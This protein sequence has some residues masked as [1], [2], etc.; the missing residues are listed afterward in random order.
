MT[1]E[2]ENEKVLEEDTPECKL[3]GN[4][5][6]ESLQKAE[7]SLSEYKDKYF[8]SLAE[9]ENLRKR[10][11]HEKQESIA[12]AIE[13]MLSEF[14]LP[15]DSFESALSYTDHLSSELKNWAQGFKMIAAQFKEVLENHGIVKFDSLGNPF[16][17]H[18]H[19]AVEMI[20]TREH[21]DGTVIEEITKG[22]KRGDKV[23]R[24][25]K[26]KVA[27]APL[28]ELKKENTNE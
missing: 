22:Y 23:L 20:L 28:E 1:S 21:K 7:A 24:V 25:A 11:S 26:V 13:K 17:P 27:K 3:G 4:F 5:L 14:L 10:L 2:E 6:Q 18:F 8:R 19:E 9:M 16:D 12:Y 15:L